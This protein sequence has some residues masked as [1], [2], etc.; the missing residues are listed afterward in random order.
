M[1]ISS[2]I[3]WLAVFARKNPSIYDAIFPHGPRTSKGTQ[4]VMISMIIKRVSRELK[5]ADTA[6][7]LNEIG[8]NLYASAVNAMSFDD[9]DW[10]RG[11]QPDP[12][13]SIF[14]EEVMLNPQ[15]LPPRESPYYGALLTLLA[16][17]VDTDNI[18][19]QLRE[20]GALLMSNASDS[21]DTR[22]TSNI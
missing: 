3:I 13:R 7:R 12:W 19:D 8:K 15:P 9:D 10:L 17:A 18:S 6:T 22:Q 2:A 4:Q 20:I 1:D 16:D 11:P 5:E 21:P 14:G